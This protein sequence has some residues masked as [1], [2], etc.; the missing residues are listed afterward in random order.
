MSNRVIKRIGL[1]VS[2]LLI[3]SALFWWQNGRAS[4]VLADSQVQISSFEYDLNTQFE[5][6]LT[7]SDLSAYDLTKRGMDLLKEERL[8]LAGPML[9]VAAWKDRELR[10][11]AVYAGFIELS[12]AEELW[13]VDSAKARLLTSSALGFLEQAKSIDPIHS[14]TYELLVVTYTNLGKDDLAQDA[15][16]KSKMFAVTSGEDL[17]Q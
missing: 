16:T 8:D 1:Y 7:H 3:I 6:Y 10:D 13:E 12:R 15:M 4:R 9:R 14:Y 2:A 11:A 17:S 5:Q